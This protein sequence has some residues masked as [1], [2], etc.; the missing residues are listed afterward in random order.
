VTG[1]AGVPWVP[2]WTDRRA[3]GGDVVCQHGTAI[4]VHC[5]NC[6]SGF[7]FSTEDCECEFDDEGDDDGEES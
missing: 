4:D 6:H 3:E 2:V 1:E 7:L 5:C